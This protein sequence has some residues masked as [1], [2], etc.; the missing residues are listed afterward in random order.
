MRV[1]AFDFELPE[2]AIAHHPVEP[3]DAARMLHVSETLADRVVSEL[4]DMLQS[5]DVLVLNNS[6]VIPARLFGTRGEGKVEVLLHKQEGELWRV[7]AR[8]AKRLKPDDT[9]RF[10]DGFSA[11]VV[12]KLPSGEVRIAFD[13]SGSALFAQLQQHGHMP[14]PPYI[15]RE[16]EAADHTR[17]QTVYA[18]HEGSVAAPTAG[19]H[20]TEQLMQHLQ[21]KGVEIAYVTLHVGA[22]TF[23]PV[24]VEDTKDHV[25]HSEY[26]EVEQ[27]TADQI[28]AAK[29][30]GNNVMAVGTTS[31]RIL[32]SAASSEGQLQ[33]W[34]AETDIFITPG[35]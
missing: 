30:R 8:P 13:A 23:Q 34:A 5:G 29:A 17:Y 2:S 21:E 20:F 15:K 14:L 10:A 22:G 18:K 11:R 9:I 31:L 33:P 7:F 16:D 3:R 1:D 24:K 6:K 4:P 35:Y 26:A 19:L 28:N 25:M 27:A 12:D 32:E